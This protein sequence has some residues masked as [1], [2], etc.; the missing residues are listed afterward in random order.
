VQARKCKIISLL[1]ERDKGS[2]VWTE[3]EVR[4]RLRKPGCTLCQ[5]RLDRCVISCLP[6]CYTAR[7]SDAV[8][9]HVWMRMCAEFSEAFLA[10]R[11]QAERCPFHALS[12]YAD[13]FHDG[14]CLSSFCGESRSSLHWLGF[15]LV[16]ALNVRRKMSVVDLC[17]ILPMVLQV[18]N[19]IVLQRGELDGKVRSVPFWI[20]GS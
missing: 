18:H 7:Q 9:G 8:K 4:A 13:M 10:E 1:F 12:E 17:V 20:F 5:D 15:P 19:T 3:K 2:V 14:S 16:I 6:G 11:A